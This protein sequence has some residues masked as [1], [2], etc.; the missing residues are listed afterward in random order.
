M[1]TRP[2]SS[3]LDNA[4][5][6]NKARR[7]REEAIPALSRILGIAVSP[8]DFTTLGEYRSMPYST[9]GADFTE[10]RFPKV[11]RAEAI[12]CL[13]SI[14][15]LGKSSQVLLSFCRS[16]DI[17]CLRVPR[18]PSA[19]IIFDLVDWDGDDVYGFHP[20]S[21]EWLFHVELCDDYLDSD[22]RTGRQM[23]YIVNKQT[24]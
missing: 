15:A 8:D 17:G 22:S 4:L 14:E 21:K 9:R 5:W 12:D 20:P 11:R 2:Q 16:Q 3:K 13:K 7:L 24:S 23:L 18:W 10:D 6:A 1:N 19:E